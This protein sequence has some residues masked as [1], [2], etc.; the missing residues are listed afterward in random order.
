MP[1]L[2]ELSEADQS[3][4][5]PYTWPVLGGLA[6][7]WVGSW[8]GLGI[9][10][11]MGYW[12]PQPAW[13]RGQYSLRAIGIVATVIAVLLAIGRA[14]SPNLA[15]S[16]FYVFAF[17]YS[18]YVMWLSRHQRLLVLAFFAV[19]YGPT[20]WCL[21]DESGKWGI[22]EFGERILFFLAVTPTAL[23]WMF[24]MGARDEL[25]ALMVAAGVEIMLGLVVIRL[26]PKRAVAFLVAMLVLSL[27]GSFGLQALFR[28]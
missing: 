22:A 2:Y 16:I 7:V 25:W 10:Q 4:A 18:A 5:S 9:L 15:G 13:P 19:Q 28:A 12:I 27:L 14:W 26:G 3:R 23:P 6:A 11:A 20:L 21:H 8:V 24:L 1:W 17:G